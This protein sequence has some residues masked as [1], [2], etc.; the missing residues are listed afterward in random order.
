M[1][2]RLVIHG[3][4]QGVFRDWT[5]ETA[6]AL[7]LSGWVRNR[8]DGTVETVA[9]GNA[10]AVEDFVHRCHSGPERAH[11]G[12]NRPVRGGRRRSAPPLHPA[13]II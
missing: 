11:V 4:V 5:V 10:A 7:G 6:R 8:P 3:R 9:D 2:T 12:P 13:L 1:G